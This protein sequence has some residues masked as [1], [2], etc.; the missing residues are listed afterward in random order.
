MISS[1]QPP[2]QEAF[3][4]PLK[5][6]QGRLN[7]PG[8]KSIS[9]RALILAA[10]AS[11]HSRITGLLESEDV[12]ATAA[13]LSRLGASV[14]RV[15][16]GE[17]N[18]AGRG[19]HFAKNAGQLDFGNSGTGVRLMMGAVAGSGSSAT[20]IGDASLSARPMGR[21]T[22]PLSL[23]GA[24]CRAT[25]GRLPVH[26]SAAPLKGI[27]YSIPIASAQVKSA[28]LLAALGATG[29]TSVREGRATRDHTE[30]M[31]KLFGAEISVERSG[32]GRVIRLPGP[33]SL[34]A[35][36]IIVPGDPSSAAFATVAALIVPGSNIALTNV[37]TNASRTGLYKVLQRMGADLSFSPAG[38]A[39][40]EAIADL[41]V[42]GSQLVAIDLEPDIAPSMIDEY[43]VLAIACAFAKGTSRLRGLAELRAKESDRLAAT[44]AL[45]AANGIVARIEADDLIIEGGQ[46]AGGGMVHSLGDHRIAMSAL[47]MGLASRDGVT[48]DDVEMIATSYPAFIADMKALGAM[49]EVRA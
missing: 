11:G 2:S 28:I 37:M 20:F 18:V 14:E 34:S 40:G 27:D 32:E 44:H 47:V 29:E 26:L 48:V 25:D 9:H 22:E 38:Q 6:L 35:C 5:P 49:I 23:M 19:G 12:L 8:D 42:R 36:D 30:T 1:R 3:S 33:Q 21:V 39:A 45:L 7:T 13:A 16:D 15:G 17:Y 46:P 31:L 4:S 41:N 24:I 10:L 43:P